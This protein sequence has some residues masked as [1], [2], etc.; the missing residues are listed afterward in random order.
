MNVKKH[1]DRLLARAKKD[2]YLVIRG[3]SGHY[4]VRHRASMHTRVWRGGGRTP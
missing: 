3:K 1:S 4:K 2:G